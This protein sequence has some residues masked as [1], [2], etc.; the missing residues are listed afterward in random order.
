MGETPLTKNDLLQARARAFDDLSSR[1]AGLIDLGIRL[2]PLWGPRLRKALAQITGP[3]VLEV[4]F[5]TG[6]LMSLYAGRFETT[7]VDYNPRMLETTHRRL[8]RLGLSAKLV[9]GD[10]HALPFADDSF[11]CLV[12]TD[13][14]T[15]YADPHKAMSEFFRV[16]APGG[17]LVLQEYDLPKDRNWLGMKLMRLPVWLGMPALSFGPL[18]RAVGFEHEDH[19]VGLA[20]VLHMYV[21]QKPTQPGLSSRPPQL[22]ASETSAAR[23]RS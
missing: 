17:R 19:A 15:L 13:A 21:A 23:A 6:Y 10:A 5:G 16:L 22:I 7:G 2:H 12:N 8:A 14:F 4:S 3:R 9:L 1:Y 11:D 20:G 18:L